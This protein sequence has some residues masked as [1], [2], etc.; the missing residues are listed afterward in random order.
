[1]HS[2]IPIG[3]SRLD[4]EPYQHYYNDINTKIDLCLV[5]QRIVVNGTIPIKSSDMVFVSVIKDISGHRDVRKRKQFIPF[6]W[7]MESKRSAT[8]SFQ[9]TFSICK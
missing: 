1:M 4:H 2:K 7:F 5:L 3:M 9:N 8:E 6:D